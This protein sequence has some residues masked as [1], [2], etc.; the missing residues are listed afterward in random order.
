MQRSRVLEVR[1]ALQHVCRRLPS[2][3]APAAVP[4]VVP[5][6]YN[7]KQ[8]T[9]FTPW[10]ALLS[11]QVAM[12]VGPRPRRRKGTAVCMPRSTWR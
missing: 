12:S 3:A 8:N 1:R 6:L 9:H 7:A 5:S 4:I 2:A 10:F 11:F